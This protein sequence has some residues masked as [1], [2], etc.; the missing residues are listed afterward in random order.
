[1]IQRGHSV[2][3][4]YPR[5]RGGFDIP[6]G[7]V[8]REVGIAVGNPIA[9]LIVN[10]PFTIAAVPM[11]DRVLCSMPI[12]AFT[13]YA[14]GK[15][16]QT[17]MLYYV[18][19]DERALFDDRSLLRSD[20]LLK[21]YHRITERAH[22]LPV[23]I[24]VNSQWTGRTVC[25]KDSASY[26]V[27]PHGVDNTVFHP[28]GDRC[29]RPEDYIISVVGRRHRWKGLYDL[30]DAL[31]II[32]DNKLSDRCIQLWIITQDDLDVSAAK[33]ATRAIKPENDPEIAAAL[34]TSDLFVHPSWFEG[35]GMPPLEAMACGT[36]CIITDS[37]GI[38]EYARDDENCTIVPARNPDALAD[39]IAAMI[40]DRERSDQYRRNGLKTAQQFTWDH[41]ADVLETVLS[42]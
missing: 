33:V 30:I 10:I 20:L 16:R 27:I 6:D 34:R 9:S 40:A 14:A 25:R 21:A 15:L 28:D 18:M 12:S 22:R 39:A 42:G 2:E 11:C 31:N 17:R 23:Q 7:V 5:G 36:P 8:A 32:V 37:G 38:H 4:I 26:P 19:N 3:I 41:A 29:D 24:V 13:G 35:F 1:M